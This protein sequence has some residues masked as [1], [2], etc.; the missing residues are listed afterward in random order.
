MAFSCFIL[1]I[2]LVSS[3]FKL[4]KLGFYSKHPIVFLPRSD[5]LTKVPT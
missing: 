3:Y 1:T 4:F 2:I 5:V